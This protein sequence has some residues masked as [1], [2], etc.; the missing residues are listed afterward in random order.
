MLASKKEEIF[1][2]KA[3][4]NLKTPT[5]GL[6]SAKLPKS[7]TPIS[8]RAESAKAAGVGERTYDAGKLMHPAIIGVRDDLA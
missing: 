4:E 3:K 2:R 1:K 6:T 5:G 8:T 7:H